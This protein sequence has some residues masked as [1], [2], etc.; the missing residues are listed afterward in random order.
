MHVGVTTHLHRVTHTLNE[1]QDTPTPPPIP[2]PPERKR[3][4]ATWALILSCLRHVRQ[5]N[6]ILVLRPRVLGQKS[7]CQAPEHTPAVSRGR[8]AGGGQRGLKDVSFLQYWVCP[9]ERL[10]TWEM[11]GPWKQCPGSSEGGSSTGRGENTHALGTPKCGQ[12]VH[13]GARA[14]TFIGLQ[15]ANKNAPNIGTKE[16]KWANSEAMRARKQ[17]E[18]AW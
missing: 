17:T 10:Y 13:R 18:N 12:T 4:A 7:V 11:I 6:A 16:T 9:H 1:A 3:L 14:R 15:R 2:P 5:A 8:G